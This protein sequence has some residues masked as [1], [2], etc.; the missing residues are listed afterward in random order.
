MI[1]SCTIQSYDKFGNLFLKM[2]RGR[3][4]NVVLSFIEAVS[5]IALAFEKHGKQSSMNQVKAG[6]SSGSLSFL[7]EQPQLI[8]KIIIQTC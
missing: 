2:S 1:L 6:R 5:I 8:E 3:R 4:P 7:Y